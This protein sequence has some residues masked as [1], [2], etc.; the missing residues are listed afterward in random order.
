MK[1]WDSNL[2]STLFCGCALCLTPHFQDSANTNSD[3]CT[4][5]RKLVCTCQ[6]SQYGFIFTTQLLLVL[7]WLRYA[8]TRHA[9]SAHRIKR[10]AKRSSGDIGKSRKLSIVQS[11]TLA[12]LPF[13]MPLR[14]GF[15][16]SKGVE[17]C[18]SLR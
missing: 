4:S 9:I 15:P 11:V 18:T 5:N 16:T 13:R 3:C 17:S 7:H 12:S 8:P 2:S 1:L 6:H 10:F 14:S